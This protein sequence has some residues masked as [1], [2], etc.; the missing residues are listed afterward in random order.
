M[1]FDRLFCSRA[2]ANQAALGCSGETLAERLVAFVVCKALDAACISAPARP[3]IRARRNDN[4]AASSA[5]NDFD[6]LA[7]LLIDVFLHFEQEVTVEIRIDDI[8]M[9][10][11]FAADRR[12]VPEH[13]CDTLHGPRD[14]LFRPRLAVG[15]F[16]FTQ[17]HRRQDRARPGA[18]VLRSDIRAAH[19]FEVGVYIRRRHG[20]PLAIVV[21]VLKE[22]L[23]WQLLAILHDPG[24]TPVAD[25]EAPLLATLALEM[26]L[27]LAA[28]DLDMA[29]EKSGQAVA[30]VLL[31]VASIAHPDHGRLKQVDDRRED[32]RASHDLAPSYLS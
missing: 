8:G 7:Q 29:V 28:L 27:K 3:S 26:K 4:T 12:G 5:R 1:S 19:L 24:N 10:V 30:L 16:K 25:A 32:F 21:D 20:L 18:E 23:A 9:D 31:G 17:R 15:L 6:V 2:I 22:V 14:I 13:G 11:A